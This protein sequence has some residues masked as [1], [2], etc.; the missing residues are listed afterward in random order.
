MMRYGIWFVSI[1][2]CVILST[3]VFA[4]HRLSLAWM[5]GIQGNGPCCDD[6]D[7]V[8][9]TIAVLDQGPKQTIVLVGETQL[10]LPSSWVH[11]T[12]DGRGYWCFRS[13][14]WLTYTDQDGIRR[15][16]PPIIPTRENTRCVFY[17]SEG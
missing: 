5:R 2:L 6:Y 17:F 12:Q 15:A 9:A 1:F 4:T 8:E 7:C 13:E 3:T 10:T 11:P 16:E 14:K